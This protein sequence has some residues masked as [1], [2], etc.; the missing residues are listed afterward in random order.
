[1]NALLSTI[2]ILC[3]IIFMCQENTLVRIFNQKQ[4]GNAP[5]HSIEKVVGQKKNKDDRSDSPIPPIRPPLFRSILLSSV[6]LTS[7]DQE[8]DRAHRNPA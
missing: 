1:M 2:F 7:S 4:T 5:F 3:H 6:Y 8:A